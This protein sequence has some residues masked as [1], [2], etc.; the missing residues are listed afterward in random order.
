M[1]GDK[2]YTVHCLD[3]LQAEA[4]LTHE[5]LRRTGCLG[6]AAVL[7]GV[8]HRRV[9]RLIHKHRIAWPQPLTRAVEVT[10]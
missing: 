6:D 9:V 10:R 2:P 3:L 8:T 1:I 4:E 7:L 5:A